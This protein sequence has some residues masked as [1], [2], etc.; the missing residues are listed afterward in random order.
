[1]AENLEN[2]L[3]DLFDMEDESVDQLFAEAFNSLNKCKNKLDICVARASAPADQEA[4]RGL[5]PQGEGGE[6]VKSSIRMVTPG[7]SL[8]IIS[9]AKIG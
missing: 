7:P 4:P 9:I 1:M 6:Q 3:D 2:S 8:V 5:V